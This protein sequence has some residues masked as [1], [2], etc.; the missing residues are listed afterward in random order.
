MKPIKKI[1]VVAKYIPIVGLLFIY[2]VS[3]YK[4]AMAITDEMERSVQVW[5]HVLVSSGICGELG[6]LLVM[7]LMS[8]QVAGKA[9]NIIDDFVE[10]DSKECSVSYNG[11][12]VSALLVTMLGIL[13][14]LYMITK[15]R[16]FISICS[17]LAAVCVFFTLAEALAEYLQAKENTQN[18]FLSRLL[19]PVF[20]PIIICFLQLLVTNQ[21]TVRFIYQNLRA[22]QN[23]VFL[24]LILIVILGYALA[25]AFCHFSNIYCL[26]AF[27]FRKCDLTRMEGKINT[28][29]EKNTALE[30]ALRQKAEY[31][32]KTAEQAGPFK[33]SGL[34]FD[35]LSAHIRTY[36]LKKYYNVS[37]LLSLGSLKLAKRLSRLLEP[38]RIKNNEI[39]FCE[40]TAVVELLLLNMLLFIYLGSGHPCSRF[41]ELLST[42][43]IIPI[44]L[45]SL[46]NLK[47]NK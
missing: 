47:I 38:E 43:I 7:D 35:F 13:S 27:A 4:S 11:L 17:A 2:A 40:I 9:L 12:T 8:Q 25:M 6:S 26:I 10:Q 24:I 15:L 45:S 37:Y 1:G 5:T 34:I 30:N 33:K 21:K 29:Q 36:C 44:L 28:I 32:D 20:L 31:I 3:L 41:F 42:V 19:D 22:P 16:V 23:T 14:V 39:R 46:S 18:P